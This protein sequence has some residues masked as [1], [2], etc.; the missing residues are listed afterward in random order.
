M[1]QSGCGCLLHNRLNGETAGRWLLIVDNMVDTNVLFGPGSGG[2]SGI[3]EYLPDSE[4]RL[5]VFTT[6]YQET[7]MALAGNDVI[8]LVEIV[9]IGPRFGS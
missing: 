2:S 1:H 5:I 8:E 4:N 7:V 3:V 6:R 9:V